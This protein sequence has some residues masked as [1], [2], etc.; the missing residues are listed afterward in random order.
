GADGGPYATALH[1]LCVYLGQELSNDQF[2]SL[3]GAALGELTEMEELA[4]VL[5]EPRCPIPLPPIDTFPMVSSV[6]SAE[7]TQ[8]LQHLEPL[9]VVPEDIS[10]TEITEGFDVHRWRLSAC[11]QY[12]SWLQQAASTD[13]D[14]VIF[15]V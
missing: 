11:Q 13:K 2:D 10:L 5:I 15:L 8:T 14:L 9:P 7:A 4:P 6:T 3:N 12:R 1:L